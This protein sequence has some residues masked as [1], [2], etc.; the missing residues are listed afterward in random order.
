M[1]VRELISELQ[2]SDTG[3]EVQIRVNIDDPEF[4]DE[5]DLSEWAGEYCN[6][7]NEKSVLVEYG[8]LTL[9]AD[10]QPLE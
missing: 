4:N 2:E 1:K 10:W 6:L 8:K 3:M 5:L 7:T 9:V